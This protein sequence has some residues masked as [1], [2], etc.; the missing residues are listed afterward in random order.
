MTRDKLY[1]LYIRELS[2]YSEA[3]RGYTNEDIAR[4]YETV[5]HF[6]DLTW[7]DIYDG[8]E[9]V[10]FILITDFDHC[11]PNYGYYVMETYIHPK[12]RKKG[13]VTKTLL[14]FIE[15][16]PSSYGLHILKGNI[17]AISFWTK[18]FKHK[19]VKQIEARSGM[20]I[21]A[22]CIETGFI[23]PPDFED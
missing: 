18:F 22:Q 6:D 11:P 10:G 1:E 21:P 16:H 8:L 14:A 9:K 13:L 5:S 17:D 19:E 20:D 7:I 12:Y 4:Q 15:N 2:L 3:L 23:A